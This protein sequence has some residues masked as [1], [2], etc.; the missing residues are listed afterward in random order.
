MDYEQLLQQAHDFM[1]FV[2]EFLPKEQLPSYAHCLTHYLRRIANHAEAAGQHA[3]A[4]R[5][6]SSADRF[7]AGEY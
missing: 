2:K 5:L 7:H 1:P 3:V 6:R 4:S